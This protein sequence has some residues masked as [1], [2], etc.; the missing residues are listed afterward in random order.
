MKVGLY[1]I[2][3]LG[4]WYDGPALAL[5]E[6]MS[7]AKQFGY[8][9]IEIDGKRP[10]G[11]PMDLDAAAREAIRN[12]AARLG[13][14]IVGVAGN[15]DFS[16]PV[17]EHRECQ[18]LMV[19]E[20]I[21]LC[22]DLGGKVVRLFGAW[23]GITFHNGVG[24]YDMAHNAF[25]RAFPDYPRLERMRHIQSCLKEAAALAAEAGVI[26]AL[27]NHPPLVRHWRDV[28][29]LVEAVDNAALQICLDAPMLTSYED[30]FVRT[31]ALTV[32]PRQVHSHFGGEFD[33]AADGRVRLRPMTFG[34][35]PINYPV[36][37]RAMKDIGYGGYFCYEFC[38]PAVNKK[39]EPLGLAFI[40]QQVQLAQ[41]YLRGQIAAVEG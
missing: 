18:L 9:G 37:L 6:V 32:G 17:P 34:Q 21:R 1:S 33:E 39:D 14:E 26:V 20:Q 23:P 15:N 29:D 8:D 27:Q 30:D 4:V 22:R 31:A 28:V 5:Q 3:Y 41:R 24:S 11:N 7:R 10:H 36:F 16:S 25:E 2:S 40:D 38:H 35:A 19:R 13:L 12:Q